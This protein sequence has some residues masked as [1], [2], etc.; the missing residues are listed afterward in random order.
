WGVY[1]GTSAATPIVAAIYALTGNANVGPSFPYAHTSAYWDVVGSSVNNNGSCTTSLC[2]SGVGWDGE[3]GIGTPNAGALAQISGTAPPPPDMAV[4]P[5]MAKPDDMAAPDSADMASP[6][7]T[8][9][10]GSGGT[11]GGTGTGGNGGTGGTGGGNGNHGGGSGCSLGG[12]TAGNGLPALALM[13]A[14]L[15]LTIYRRRRA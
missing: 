5:D 7:G 8:G 11:G 12:A 4:G 6:G 15:G 10:G 9:T 1:G 3:T 2:I 14:L 13:L